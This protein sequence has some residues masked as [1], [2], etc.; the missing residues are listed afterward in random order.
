MSALQTWESEI[1]EYWKS[2][3]WFY[4]Y[5]ASS[6]APRFCVNIQLKAIALYCWPCP[7]ELCHW[8]RSR[9]T[10]AAWTESVELCCQ[11]CLSLCNCELAA[12]RQKSAQIN[13]LLK[14]W[15][16]HAYESVLRLSCPVFW[17][18]PCHYRKMYY[19]W[20][21]K[22]MDQLFQDKSTM[23]ASCSHFSVR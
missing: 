3:R 21:G 5:L 7:H 11:A 12:L 15:M 1:R 20:C 14:M 6:R 2:A 16:V 13:H 22:G 10:V 9:I 4:K 18:I 17:S 8:S 23:K 19:F